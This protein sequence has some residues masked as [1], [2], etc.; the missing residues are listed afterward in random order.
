MLIVSKFHDYYDTAIGATDIDKTCVYTRTTKEIDC[1]DVFN[2][3]MPVG[4]V[5]RY[6]ENDFLSATPF[7]VG[8]CGK[9]YIG[10]IFEYEKI[11]DGKSTTKR[12]ITYNKNNIIKRLWPG[13]KE[14]KKWYNKYSVT[15]MNEFFDKY[16]RKENHDLFRKH[17]VPIFVYVEKDREKKFI[18][19][20][21]L[22]NYKFY[23]IFATYIAFQ[24]IHMYLSGVLGTQEKDIT[25]VSEKHRIQQ[26]GFNKWSFRNPDPPKRKQRKNKSEK[27]G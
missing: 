3:G 8:F 4:M 12:M 21:N 10:Y 27:N 5:R 19:N 26:R 16:D 1:A 14:M 17:K 7:I 11:I 9:T 24:E 20:P 2:E 22:K 15:M 23:R 6:R 18:L 25:A 13:Q